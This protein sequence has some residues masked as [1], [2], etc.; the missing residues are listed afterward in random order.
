MLLTEDGR[1]AFLDFGLM[2]TVEPR[3]MDARMRPSV[4]D[5][6]PRSLQ[7]LKALRAF[8]SLSLSSL[9]LAFSSPLSSILKLSKRH[10]PSSPTPFFL[11]L[12]EGFAAGIQHLLAER[13]LPL[14]KVMQGAGRNLLLLPLLPSSL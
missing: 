11:V 1:L 3:I 10:S 13:W 14:A 7:S 8:F 12:Q 6:L 4:T 5:I 2:G 9:P